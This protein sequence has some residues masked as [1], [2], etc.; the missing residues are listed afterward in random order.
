[1]KIVILGA[2]PAGLLLAHYLLSH[3]NDYQILIYDK[4]S[5][6]RQI[7]ENKRAFV[8]GIGK[9]G[10]TVL[11]TI[12]GLWPAI[13][14]KGIPVRKSGFYSQKKGEWKVFERYQD[15]DMCNLLINRNDLCSVL[16]EELEKKSNPNIDIQFNVTCLDV[17]L[18]SH[19]IKLEDKN[20]D[21]FEQSYDL[22]VGA[23]GVHSP[24]R[25]A[26]MSQPGFDFEQSYFKTHWKVIH[27]PKPDFMETETSYGFREF[28]PSDRIVGAAL[29]EVNNQICLLM[30]WD[31]NPEI[32]NRNPFNINTVEEMQKK[33]K[34]TLL[35][36]LE[37]TN[38]QAQKLLNKYPSTVV[39][40]KCN[41]YHDLEGKVALI[42]DAAHGMSSRLGQGCQAAFNDAI[43]L[44][45]LLVEENNNL[46]LVLPKYSEKQVKEGHAI[47]D[48]NADLAPRSQWVSFLFN[49]VMLIRSKLNKKFP[50]LIKP[51]AAT[52]VSQTLIPYSEIAAR[53][54]H[55][56]SLIKWSNERHLK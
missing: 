4:R 29:P 13:K 17:N 37:L 40:T 51:T 14:N 36:G 19:I 47:T 50:N 1:M 11:K 52:E 24:V 23:D 34:E 55:W 31:Q 26:L 10:Q 20:S 54:Q 8:I 53:F 27:I 9:R 21:F 43:A 6:P 15:A 39:Q 7:D 38:D 56:M 16:L 35:P 30:F 5:D 12:D 18:R 22:L 41:R 48:M 33:I 49:T 42:G 44:Y 25:K 28:T 2:G 32:L 3:P 45:K 46:S